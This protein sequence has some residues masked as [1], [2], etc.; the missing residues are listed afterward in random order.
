MLETLASEDKEKYQTFWK[1]FGQVIKEGPGEDITNREQIAKLLRFATTNTDNQIQEV[2]LEEYVSRMKPGQ[3]KIYYVTAETFDA[4]K[5]SP[6]LEIF[7]KKSI[8]VLLLSD[9]VDEWFIMHLAEYSGKSLQSIAKGDLNLGKLE[10][11]EEKKQQKKLSGDFESMIKQMKGILG[12]RVKDIR[13]TYRLTT[14][15]ACIVND[16][17]DMSGHMQR[18]LQAAGHTTPDIKPIFEINSQ[19]TLI[20]R[21]R[22]EQDDNRFAEFSHILFDQAVLVE[23]GQLKNTNE[24]VHRLNRLILELTST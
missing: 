17:I 4:A 19:H 14:S 10:D 11:E 2:S 24:F 13:L 1:A 23:D 3:E 15:P 21:L 12:D 9:N 8:E 7:K 20:Q 6:H 18:L 22:E 16:E 5:N